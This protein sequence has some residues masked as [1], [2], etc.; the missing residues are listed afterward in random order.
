MCHD[1]ITITLATVDADVEILYFVNQ[2][3]SHRC[4]CENS[5]NQYEPLHELTRVHIRSTR[6]SAL[7]VN[8]ALSPTYCLSDSQKIRCHT[9]GTSDQCHAR[10]ETAV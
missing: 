8:L 6:A 4:E 9:K 5:M 2:L 10:I 7:S 3:D 1:L